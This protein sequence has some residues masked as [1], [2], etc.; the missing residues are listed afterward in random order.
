MQ[1]MTL[2]EMMISVTLFTIAVAGMVTT[3]LFALS[4]DQL[5]NSKSGACELARM[6]F[7]DLASDIRAA[8]VWQL[9]NGNL[10]A[11]APLDEDATQQGTALQLCMTTDT[12]KFYLYYFDTNSRTL[13]RHHK[14]EATPR[15]LAYN[16]TNTMYFQALDYRGNVQTTLNHKSTIATV[17]QFCQYQYP[18]TKIGPNYYYNYYQII[19]RATPHVPDGP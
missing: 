4:Q 16:L 5:V 9:G 1:G 14:G 13:Y 10:A 6:S 8:K 2:P 3:Q 18:I 11:F 17:M 19:V 15:A 12:N 7:N